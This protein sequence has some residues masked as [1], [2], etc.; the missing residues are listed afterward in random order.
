MSF[1]LSP[2]V[3]T[4][5][6]DLTTGIE[7][8]DTRTACIAASMTWGPL[9][10]PLLITSQ[11]NLVLNFGKPDANTYENWF[12][13]ANFLDYSNSLYVVR[14]GDTDNAINVN[15]ISNATG[16]IAESLGTNASLLGSNV[17]ATQV[18]G[19]TT[20]TVTGVNTYW[21]EDLVVGDIVIFTGNT[22]ELP[23]A[24]SYFA[25]R[26][27]TIT[28]NTAITLS[29]FTSSAAMTV[30]AASNT[31][32]IYRYGTLIKNDEDFFATADWGDHGMVAAK[33]PGALGNSLR[34]SVCTSANLFETAISAVNCTSGGIIGYDSTNAASFAVAGIIPGETVLVYDGEEY[35]INSSNSTHITTTANFGTDFNDFQTSWGFKPTVYIRWKYAKYFENPPSTSDFAAGYESSNDEIHVIVVDEYGL[36][37]GRR[38]SILETYEGLSK[39]VDAKSFDGTDIYFLTHINQRSQYIR[40]LAP[41]VTDPSGAAI[42][43]WGGKAYDG[44]VFG[45]DIRTLSLD[46]YNGRDGSTI[47]G[48]ADRVTGYDMFANDIDYNISFVISGESTTELDQYIIDNIVENRQDCIA[49]FS[50]LQTDVVNIG[51][52][53]KR[54]QLVIATKN[55]INRSTS[56]GVMDCNWKYQYDKYNDTY[57][58]VP[59]NGDIAGLCAKTDV[60][61]NPWWSPGGM[62]RGKIKNVV[63]FAWNPDKSERDQLYLNNINPVLS[64]RDTGPVLW[65]DKTMLAKNSVFSRI[66]VRRL[67]IVLRTAIAEY[68]K[69]LL[70]EFND[71]FTRYQFKNIVEPYLKNV[72]ALRGIEDFTVVCD[73]TN[74]TPEVRNNNQFVGDIYIIPNKS[75]NFIKLNFIAVRSGVSFEEVVGRIGV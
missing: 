49:F 26:V 3:T 20:V 28:S 68:A 54:L 38:Q 19:N 30:N 9:E 10:E 16:G 5:E 33:Y 51:M 6:I 60:D 46:M 52:N 53:T 44:L 27:E 50:P 4:T 29:N 34:V 39:A 72:Q 69:N 66:N 70:F 36:F 71:E 8:Q 32:V 18:E 13:A 56:Y 73:E 41:P 17:T 74:N 22:E 43:N 14:V 59:V 48:M 45:S 23:T 75:I 7:A 55:A 11:D 57:R 25:C 15:Q 42:T 1:S 63:R 35:T 47:N 40:F 65:G 64:F 12:A 61:Y 58:W 2:A 21:D 62:T 67:F 37:T 24:T 31:G